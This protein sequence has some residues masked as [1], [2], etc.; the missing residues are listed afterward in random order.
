VTAT[1]STFQGNFSDG[2]GVIG[3]G[4]GTMTV[5]AKNDTAQNNTGTG[6]NVAAGGN[7]QPAASFTL[8][9][10]TLTG[11]Q[12]NALNVAN[13]GG[14]TFTGHVTNDTVGTAGTANSGST[15]GSGISLEQEGS[16]TLTADVSTNT[17]NQVE[18]GYGIT[19]A[20]GNG[21]GHLN[22]SLLNNNVHLQAT[23][24]LDAITVDSGEVPTT[25][26]DVVCLA[27]SGNTAASVATG[28]AKPAG[29]GTGFDS[30][31]F[32]VVRQTGTFDIQGDTGAAPTDTDVQNLLIGS[33]TLS[34]PTNPTDEAFAQGTF[35]Q[36]T[37]TCPTAPI[38]P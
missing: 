1:N 8:D 27:A 15:A 28:A 31:G 14:G 2:L 37:G 13:L 34:G 25:D 16:G 12:G 35:P 10:D 18:K 11:Q 20:D 3:N 32:S 33:N 30:A 38:G 36:F 7:V 5:V 4:N 17:V 9:H 21:S 19:A 23:S 26:T 29:N 6:I 24:S 22:L